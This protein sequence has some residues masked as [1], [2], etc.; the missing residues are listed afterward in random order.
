MKFT[1]ENI[2]MIRNEHHNFEKTKQISNNIL[3]LIYDQKLFKLFVSKDLGGEMLELP[4][5]VKI[6]QEASRIDGNFGWIVTIGSGGGMFAPNMT[7]ET[8]KYFY[9]PKEAVIAGSGF[10]AGVAK[11][12]E[13]GYI[14]NGQWFYCSGSQY[15]NCFTATCIVDNKTE[16]KEE[17]IA[18]ALNPDEVKI[19]ENW[20]AFGLKGTSSHTIEVVN[21]FIPND[22]VFSVLESQNSFGGLVHTF[23]FM[24]FSEA[25]FGAI[26]LGISKHFLEEVNSILEK[27]KANWQSGSNNRYDMLKNKLIEEENRWETANNY[28][29]EII[30][31]SWNKHIQGDELTEELKIKFST[32]SKRSVTT[33]IKCVDNLYRYLGM[34][35][36]MESNT[37]NQ[38]WRDLHTASQHTFLTPKNKIEA[39]SF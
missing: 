8:A 20:D 35:V 13:K 3:K 39:K 11:P 23:P 2:Q 29:H 33:T 4:D 34:Q 14:I 19:I 5:A 6:F 27:N 31:S 1:D 15:A 12:T 38:I 25:S 36:V 18:V 9:S 32:I 30:Q 24:M 28:F 37:L 7:K 26:S 16:N 10:P 22:R 21:E 17:I